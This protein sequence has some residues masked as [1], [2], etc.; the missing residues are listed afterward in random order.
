MRRG[1]SVAKASSGRLSI[2][3]ICSDAASSDTV[4]GTRRPLLSTSCNEVKSFLTQA[5]CSLDT[6][7]E[8]ISP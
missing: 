7:A 8:C 1:V 4:R 3:D 2:T 6:K 5:D